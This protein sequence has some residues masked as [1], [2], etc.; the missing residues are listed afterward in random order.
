MKLLLQELTVIIP[1]KDDHYR[2]EENIENLLN[3]LN[4]NIQ[5][6][7]ILIVSNGSSVFSQSYID[8]LVLGVEYIKHL[9]IDKSGKGLAVKTGITNSKY[10]NVLYIDADLSVDISEFT[11]FVQRGSLLSGFV[12]GNR[13]N[14]LSENLD[15]PILRKFSGFFYLLLIKKLFN[16]VFE[17]TQCGFKAI[18]KNIF[19]G[20]IDYE[21]KGFSFDL[22]L[23]LLA[24]KENITISEVPVKYVHNANSKV[25]IFKDTLIMIQEVYKVYK[26]RSNYEKY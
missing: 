11:N 1:T 3:Y 13:K 7:E 24:R 20:C 22:E 26:K 14:A 2:V 12:V 25:K 18:D 8:D 4:L 16:L 9:K 23:F 19:T 15:S 5:R 6:F 17:D 10:K 21:T